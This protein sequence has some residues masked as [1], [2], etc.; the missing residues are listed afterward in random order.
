LPVLSAIMSANKPNL[1]TQAASTT[2]TG[3]REHS[4]ES[5]KTRTR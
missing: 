1:D 2:A 4:A 5:D 3:H